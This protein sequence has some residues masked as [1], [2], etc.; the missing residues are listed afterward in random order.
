MQ[1]NPAYNST[2][3]LKIDDKLQSE[4]SVNITTLTQKMIE[5]K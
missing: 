4:D 3:P 2:I 1:E 5:D